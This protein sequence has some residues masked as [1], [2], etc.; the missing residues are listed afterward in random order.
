MSKWRPS[1]NCIFVIPDIHGAIDLLELCLVRILP[2]RDKNNKKDTIVFLGD[3]ID[4]HEDSPLVINTII[5]LKKQYPDQVV[6]LKGNHEHMLLM[7]LEMYPG[8]KR[9]EY[10]MQWNMWLNNGGKQTLSGYLKIAKQNKTVPN[11]LMLSSITP[12]AVKKFNIIPDDHLDFM[13]NCLDFYETDKFSFV[14]G[15][16]NP[17]L[18]WQDHPPEVLYW[19]RKLFELVKYNIA[20]RYPMQWDKVIISGH[21][22]PNTLFHDKYMMIDAGSPRQLLILEANSR[23]AFI[24]DSQNTKL[25]KYS[26]ANSIVKVGSFRRVS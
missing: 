11:D 20:N 8:H 2:L 9:H 13:M 15:G 19:D 3:Y 10:S 4:R 17:A 12:L 5:E 14:H 21:C 23:Q 16:G 18:P 24:A 6:C 25:V 26:T 22:G 1:D 7:G